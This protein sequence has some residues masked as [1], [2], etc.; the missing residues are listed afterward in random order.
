MLADIASKLTA[1]GCAGSSGHR[2]GACKLSSTM[3]RQE[4]KEMWTDMC[5][6]Q[7]NLPVG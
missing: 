1:T 3:S 7:V 4:S 2:E 6:I 5:A